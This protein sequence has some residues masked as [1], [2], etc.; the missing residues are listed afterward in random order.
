MSPFCYLGSAALI[1]FAIMKLDFMMSL[2]EIVGWIFFGPT[3][4][5]AVVMLI[6]WFFQTPLGLILDPIGNWLSKRADEQSLVGW[7][8]DA[9]I[10]DGRDAPQSIFSIPL[11]RRTAILL[12]QAAKGAVCR[13]Y[14]S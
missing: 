10:C 14:G 4:L 11:G 6:T 7:H 2:L 9:L 8:T 5:F 1:A 13:P 12:F 3:A